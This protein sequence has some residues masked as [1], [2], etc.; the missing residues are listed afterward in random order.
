MASEIYKKVEPLQFELCYHRASYS[1]SGGKYI[2]LPERE[3]DTD[4]N[5]DPKVPLVP[6]GF[7]P[8]V[9]FHSQVAKRADILNKIQ[10]KYSF[11]DYFYFPEVRKMEKANG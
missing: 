9:G 8:L 7:E 5:G 6:E 4:E 10:E 3:V 11:M 2:P 1:I